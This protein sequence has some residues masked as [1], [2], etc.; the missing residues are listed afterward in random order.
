MAYLGFDYS[1]YE[2]FDKPTERVNFKAHRKRSLHR[3]DE[4]FEHRATQK[5]ACAGGFANLSIQKSANLCTYR[6]FHK[7]CQN[8]MSVAFQLLGHEFH[9]L[10]PY[11]LVH[12]WA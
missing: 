3:V 4:H 5:L 11:C 10:L 8:I 7:H 1:L 9:F 12:E 2:G 6:P